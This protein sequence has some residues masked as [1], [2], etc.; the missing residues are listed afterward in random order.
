MSTMHGQCT[1]IQLKKQVKN[2][3]FLV[4]TIV[5]KQGKKWEE[6]FFS[7]CDVLLLMLANRAVAV[8]AA[9]SAWGQ[10]HLWWR[11]QSRSINQKN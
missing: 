9:D 5:E 3:I 11:G 6:H 2:V 10:R 7:A 8:A 4:W 1:S